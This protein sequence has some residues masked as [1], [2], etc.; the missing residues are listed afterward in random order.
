MVIQPLALQVFVPGLRRC[1]AARALC[2]QHP[3]LRVT[4]RLVK[5]GLAFSRCFL[6]AQVILKRQWRMVSYLPRSEFAH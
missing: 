1:L 5:T 4:L 3:C 2:G 6:A